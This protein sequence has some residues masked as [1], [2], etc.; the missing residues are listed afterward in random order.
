MADPALFLDP[1]ANR[2]APPPRPG[3]PRF[4]V[5]PGTTT[6]RTQVKPE[7]PGGSGGEEGSAYDLPEYSEPAAQPAAGAAAAAP[8]DENN[9]A[10]DL[11][12]YV[13]TSVPM[14][15]ERPVG[16]GEAAATGVLQGATL[17]F[18]PAMAGAANAMIAATPQTGPLSPG[19]VNQYE[20]PA[21]D[22]SA[23][24]GPGL[25][26]G[27]AALKNLFASNPDQAISTAYDQGR[28][29]ALKQQDLARTQHPGAYY[30]GMVAGSLMVPAPGLGTA[31][32]LGGNVARAAGSG[33]VIGGISGVGEGVSRGE[34]L[35]EI[36]ARAGSGA[37][38]GGAVGAPFGAVMPRALPAVLSPGQRAARTS[39]DLG[40]PL[41]WGVTS[42]SPF[43]QSTT[44][45][46]RQVPFAG[47]RI[48]AGV[49]RTEHAAGERIED[50]AGQMTGGTRDRAAADLLMR[51]GL[52]RAIE[53][54]RRIA[55]NLY[56]NVRARIDEDLQVRMPETD[57][58]LTEIM[59]ARQA[60]GHAN[61]AEGLDQFR[62]VAGGAT[63]A[64]AQR[65]RADARDAGGLGVPHPGF[66]KADFNRLTAAMTEDLRRIVYTAAAG[67]QAHKQA[68]VR[69]FDEAERAFG[70]IADLNQRLNTM[71]GAKGEG[72]IA[73][74]LG[75]AKERGGDLRLLAQLRRSM[76]QADFNHIGG[77]LLYELGHS[78]KTNEFSLAQFVT[79]WDKLSPRARQ[80]L[81]DPQHLRDIEEI[82]GMGQHIKRALAESSTSHSANMFV[83]FEVLKE[84][85]AA[86]YELH[87]G[88]G[89]G[90]AAAAG[91]T[92]AVYALTHMMGNPVQARAMG[93]WVRAYR[94]IS[95]GQP[96][97][98]RIA[99][100]KI[101]TR[102]LA[103]NLN[104]PVETIM[105]AIQNHLSATA[106]PSPDQKS[107][108]Q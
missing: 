72:S 27:L 106:Q 101:A 5:R 99:A 66:N 87:A 34:S 29:D 58:A 6:S 53:H 14:Q 73:T 54:N 69:A 83:A 7:V 96:T 50:Y 70:P 64:G 62:R 10:Y 76:P 105:Q 68:A 16:S 12:A 98:A 46:V 51:P 40:E 41:P 81:F 45:R 90:A 97:P 15:P 21:V 89:L 57:R 17:G 33:A 39:V 42:D 91:T 80:I 61:P 48:G 94:T 52:E 82:V 67:S 103:S 2:P 1:A 78:P 8:G 84:I 11:P 20:A 3:V 85:A 59:R 28:Q 71:A 93:N 31:G 107:S 22:P 108:R 19:Q 18:A 56:N 55:D 104:L 43:I 100:F 75:A 95:L 23:Y 44:A 4:T 13:D 30:P 102:N 32:T 60:A 35:P 36:A 25:A 77:Q 26:G 47:E 49:H 65:A 37:V 86:V 63:F 74:L 24:A 38:V 9:S 79:G 88:T 92:G